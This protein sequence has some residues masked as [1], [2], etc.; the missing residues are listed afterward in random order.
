MSSIILNI[1]LVMA[2][3]GPMA[4]FFLGNRKDKA[5]KNDF[6]SLAGNHG[7][8]P[9]KVGLF[10]GGAVGLDKRNGK[11]VFMDNDT[12][13]SLDISNI[14]EC[15]V[16]KSYVK[17]VVHNQDTNVLKS[18]VLRILTRDKKEVIVPVYDMNRFPH[19]GSDLME[20]IEWENII[21]SSVIK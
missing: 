15:S 7:I 18:V 12:V 6:K 11:L 17:E 3:I 8:N 13:R 2:V 16:S 1:L 21:N 9:D 19:P 4:Y 14:A 20:A 10:Q 5:R